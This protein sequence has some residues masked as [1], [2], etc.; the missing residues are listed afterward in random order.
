MAPRR[1][2]DH[3]RHRHQRQRG[4]R[5]PRR[6]PGDTAEHLPRRSEARG[7]NRRPGRLQRHRRFRPP[8]HRGAVGGSHRRDHLPDRRARRSRPGGRFVGELRQT[9]RR[10]VQRDRPSPR[11]GPRGRGCGARLRRLAAR[12]RTTRLRLP[13]GG[14]TGRAEGGHRAFADRAY[15]P[16][17]RSSPGA[18]PV[19]YCTIRTR[20]PSG[21]CAWSPR[22]WSPRSTAATYS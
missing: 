10:A 2:R 15:T 18:N 9:P 20:S 21:S 13:R 22:G 4:V 6:R 8:V 16:E 3:A 11:T 1:R 7:T 19:R 17:A 5:I 14:R 12:P